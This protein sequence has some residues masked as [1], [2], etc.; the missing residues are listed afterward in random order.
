MIIGNTSYSTRAKYWDFQKMENLTDYTLK[1][2]L[3]FAF[4]F[5]S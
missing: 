2:D 5:F 1:T 3:K 4:F